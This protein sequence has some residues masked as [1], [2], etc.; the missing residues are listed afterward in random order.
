MKLSN[1]IIEQHDVNGHLLTNLYSGADIYLNNNQYNEYTEIIS[2]LSK[3]HK[4]EL[5]KCL[6]NQLF[7]LKDDYDECAVMDLKR[8]VSIFNMN[9]TKIKYVIAPTLACNARCPYCYEKDLVAKTPMSSDTVNDLIS[10]IKK[11]S[12]GKKKMNIS[13]FGGEPLLNPSVIERIS[14]EIIPFCDKNGID[15]YANM[16]TN[17]ILT[18]Q[19]IELIKKAK[20]E[21]IQIT[22]DGTKD[23]YESVKNYINIENAFQHILDN[24]FLL[25][26]E[27]YISIRMNVDRDNQDDLKELCRQ[28]LTDKRW[29]DKIDIYFY[30]LIDYYRNNSDYFDNTEY[31]AMFTSLYQNLFELGYYTSAKQ[32]RIK[33]RSISCYGWD[34]TTFAIGP[35]GELYNCQHE[36]GQPE[37]VIGNIKN[38]LQITQKF[39]NEHS[40]SI[41]SQ[42]KDCK[43]LPVC[44]G[45]CFFAMRAKNSAAQCQ[46]IKYECG[47][48]MKLL[49]KFLNDGGCK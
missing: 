39:V 12:M 46:S 29:N 38:G 34:M 10:F 44:Q 19:Y 41:S 48:R 26:N 13:W 9:P 1:Y 11:T 27:T 8:N 3:E 31:E 4:S 6:R 20:I 25:S 37:F 18:D 21:T 40:K 2:D 23:I 49:L 47:I 32:F 28:L 45:G 33:P 14:S 7:I 42:C 30:P 35:S 16:T 17:G 5:Y 22:L 24:I 36:L 43:Y 15:Y